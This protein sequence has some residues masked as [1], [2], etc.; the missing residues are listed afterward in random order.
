MKKT[1]IFAALAALVF[2]CGSSQDDS[3]SS[4]ASQNAQAV[5]AAEGPD[6]EELY[7]TYCVTCHGLYGDMGASGA[8]NLKESELS[9]EERIAV[10][11][12][13]RKAMT[14]FESL[15]DKDEI[16]AVSKYTMKLS[17]E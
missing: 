3:R 2:A 10:V 17:E 16:K 9:L 1:L 13:G 11:T 12:K 5:A 4:D 8:Y 15:L 6:G 14:A 7:K